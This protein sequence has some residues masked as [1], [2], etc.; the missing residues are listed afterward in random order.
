MQERPEHHA[1]VLR[2]HWGSV[3]RAMYSL[4]CAIS[5]GISWDQLTLSFLEV[6][7]DEGFI[8]FVVFI[9]FIFMTVFGILNIVTSIF[10]ESAVQASSSNRDLLVEEKVRQKKMYASHMR[11]IF[12][13]ID[14][15]G[16]GIISQ[17]EVE[18]M[19][20]DPEL[21]AYVEA[22]EVNPSDA[23][24]L[25]SF[26]DGDGSGAIDIDEFCQGCLRLKGEAKS[27]DV[28]CLIYESERMSV[29]LDKI[30]TDIEAY[31]ISIMKEI[32]QVKEH[33]KET[34]AAMARHVS[35]VYSAK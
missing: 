32:G 27:F 5:N 29:K 2:H 10:V 3:L 30:Y 23:L 15:D 14:E 16:S 6:N 18:C 7:S 11:S 24:M 21:A 17:K 4:Y 33:V 34:P 13:I 20:N 1:Q 19:F 26:L 28:Y 25:F 31:M 22:L 12:S 8:A 9:V 35:R